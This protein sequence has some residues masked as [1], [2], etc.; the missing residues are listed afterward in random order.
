M[1]FLVTGATGFVGSHLCDQLEREG[2]EV[3]ALVRSEKKAKEFNVKGTLLFGDL[4][5]K[6]CEWVDHLPTDIDVVVHT[7]GIVHSLDTQ[8]FYEVNYE[9][10]KTLSNK[11]CEHLTNQ[12]KFIFISSLAA[13]GPAVNK[14]IIDEEDIPT[15]VS[16]YGKSKLQTELWL[17]ENLRDRC[18]LVIIRP[19]MVIGPRDVAILDV[20]KMVQSKVILIPGLNGENKSYS[21]VNV[22]DLCETIYKTANTKT[23]FGDIFYSSHPQ[24]ITMRE[25]NSEIKKSMGNP[26]TLSIKAPKLLMK[27]IASLVGLLKID[28]RLTPDKYNEIAPDRWVCSGEKSRVVLSQDYTWN[29]SKT[30]EM[31]YNDYKERGWL[32]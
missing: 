13:A 21:F 14:E 30:I 4:S 16:D 12:F 1:K 18:D 19:P 24:V 31:T 23:R 22:F 11:L 6:K 15:P 20:F 17:K 5:A 28:V 25:L 10:T 2:H 32:N 9:A 7:A 8:A 27:F 29:I 26:R 3:Y